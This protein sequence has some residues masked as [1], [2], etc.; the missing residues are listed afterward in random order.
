VED[1]VRS[2]WEMRGS[3]RD[4]IDG[5]EFVQKRRC[6]LWQRRWGRR[7]AVLSSGRLQLKVTEE[8]DT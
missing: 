8:K 5:R 1:A 6:A 3:D 4:N 7:F 2:K